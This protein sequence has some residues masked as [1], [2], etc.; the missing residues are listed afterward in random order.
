M[1]AKSRM[2]WKV[3]AILA[4]RLTSKPGMRSSRNSRSLP[5]AMLWFGLAVSVSK[6]LQAARLPQHHHDHGEP[7]QQEAVLAGVEVRAE[8]YFHE[9]EFTQQFHAADHDE[10]GRG[11]TE[12]AAHAA[13]HDDGQHHHRFHEDEALRVHI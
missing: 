1:P 3:L 11:D 8:D 4:W 9:T 5:T 13:E 6:A 7:E 12:E 2:F 10:R